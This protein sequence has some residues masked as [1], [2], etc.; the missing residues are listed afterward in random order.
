[1]FERY[2][3]R[4]RRALFFARYEASH[5]GS[6][7]IGTEH[8]LLGLIREGRG[9]AAQLFGRCRVSTEALRREIEGRALRRDQISTSVEI[10]LAADCVQA[11]SD[12]S[13]EADRL[14][15]DYVGTEHILLGI[16]RQDRSLAARVLVDNGLDLSSARAHLSQL[17]GDRP[18]PSRSRE[19]LPL[20]SEFARDISDA[21]ARGA[22]DP[23]VGRERE[24]ERVVQILCRRTRNNP[25]LIGDPGVG[26][27][28]LVEGLA[29][30]IASGDVPVHLRDRRL[31]SLD[32]SLIVAGTKF[33]GQFEERLK[34]LL[35]EL[36]EHREIIVFIDELHTLVGAGSAE[37]SLDAANILKPALSRGEIQCIGATTP[38]EFRRHI[39]KDRALARRFQ[40]VRV[41]PATPEESRAILDGLKQR[42]EEYHGIVFDEAALDGA[43]D[44]SL[45]YI[46]DRQLPDK[47]I[48]LLDEAGSRV[49]LRDAEAAPAADV[50]RRVRIVVDRSDGIDDETHEDE[51]AVQRPRQVRTRWSVGTRP[52]GIVTRGDVE[53]VVA[54]WT[55]IPVTAVREDESARLLRM[56]EELHRRIVSQD[57][58]VSAVARSIRR[59]RSGLKD[60]R[61]PMGSF[62]FLGPTGV[63]KTELARGLAA[64]LFGSES[65]LVRLDM[66]EYM[67][68]H[69]VARMIGAPPGY[70][71]HEE[72]GQLTERLRR[73]PY[74]V[75]LFDEIE[76]AHPEVFNALLQVLDDGQLTDSLGQ[77][78][79]CRNAIFILT[80]NIG[81]RFLVKGQGLGFSAGTTPLGEGVAPKVME[82]VRRTFN[83]EFL[84][85]LDEIIVFSPLTEDD[86]VRVAGLLADDLTR[87]LTSRALPLD[88]DIS[89]LRWL[90]A[91]TA[92]ERGY[93][94]RPLRRLIERHIGDPI[95]EALL[96]GRVVEGEPL[97]VRAT[98]GVLRYRQGDREGV[99]AAPVDLPGEVC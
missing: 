90:V 14:L 99:L 4:A 98:E 84:N 75:V 54:A 17:V 69:S 27:T 44:L 46:T 45:R 34:G 64:F 91:R 30:R 83:P 7:A 29:S 24:L 82:E 97:S 60:P 58:A 43:I 25:V 52:A 95:A 16:L 37:G 71:G 42:Y 39:E 86:L 70:V 76:K 50:E 32:L 36:L 35:R 10:P 56:E 6:P 55:G 21:A 31:V 2:T 79:D 20:L 18:A 61:R 87:H 93:G 88:V 19:P 62:L 13:E 3:E 1:M 40:P 8:L 68:R 77:A 33:R 72:G 48:D 38:A 74:A 67:E 81:A 57:Q 5:L 12:A 26:K 63:G 41:A 51:D 66:S 73:S 96:G 22:L 28:A 9:P 15:H 53:E 94:A 11:L 47:A 59:A 89:A 92:S 23:L 65:H 80:S 49:K 85:R 78:V